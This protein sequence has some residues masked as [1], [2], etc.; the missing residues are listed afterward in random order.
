M[1][2][3]HSRNKLQYRPRRLAPFLRQ[4]VDDHPVVILTGARQVGKSTL[5]KQEIP[6]S[7]WRYL[8]LDDFDVLNQA[9]R[10]PSALWSGADQ[11]VIDEVQKS[12]SLLSAIKKAVDERHRRVRF[13]LSGSANL[14]LMKKV[15]ETLA[16][17]AVYF[18][19]FP[20]TRGEIKSQAPSD[21][22]KR[23]LMGQFPEE[24]KIKE[25]KESP[26]FE[27]LRGF[28]PPLLTL[29][30]QAAVLQWWEGYVATYLERDLR[31][32]SEIASLPDFR[33]VMMALALRSGQML[34][35]TE[36]SR[37]TGVSQ[38][39]AHRYINLLEATSLL[40]RL[41]AFSGNKTKRLMKA[42]KVYWIDPGIA[43][44]LS[45]H[46]DLEGLE[47][48]REAGGIFETLI[49]LHLQAAIQLL[50]P[51]PHLYY[52][53]TQAGKEVDFIVEQGR[54]V[55]GVEVKLT[56]N[57]GYADVGGLRQFLQ[58]HPN[59]IAGVLV[60]TGRDIRRFDDKIIG[61]PWD[62]FCE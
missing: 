5:L 60:H 42:P 45:G 39:T 50:V 58:D 32:M 7:R 55:I 53:R 27:M 25:S 20:M 30:R 3:N 46:H 6:F 2:E 57:P 41:P 31:Q 56:S 9:E 26:F 29:S 52:W 28:M 17:R 11:V 12:P 16:G 49:L 62:I 24:R 40:V 48:S 21:L 44:F 19:L 51:R 47:T 15:S 61:I 59:A 33:R 10:N 34:N 36:V 1:N 4:T 43:S 38:P 37:D 14:L 35:Q 8:T 18:T 54:H 23:L 22:L 13:L